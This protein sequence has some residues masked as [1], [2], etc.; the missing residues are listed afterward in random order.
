MPSPP[1]VR[2]FS[3]AAIASRNLC[4]STNAVLYDVPRSRDRASM[5]L[6]LTSLQKIAMAARYDLS[7]ILC[8]ANSVPAVSVKSFLH[9]R[10]RY[11]REQFG[12][13]AS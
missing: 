13:R 2:P 5:D 6:P 1:M 7:G 10:Q 3:S 4:A 9:A 11:R 12:R 8:E